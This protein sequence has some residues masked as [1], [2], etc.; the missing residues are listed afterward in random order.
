MQILEFTG[1]SL[2]FLD[3]LPGTAS[4]SSFVWIY[5]DR[6]ELPKHQALLQEAAQRLG[7]SPLL[8]L[9]WKDLGNDQHP[10]HYDSTSVY[11]LVIFRRLATQAEVQ[12]DA[13]REQ[14]IVAY[15]NQGFTARPRR[16]AAMPAAFARINSRAV[17]FAI[18]DRLLISVHPAGCVIANTYVQRFLSDAKLSIE[19]ASARSRLPASPADLALRTINTMVDSYLDLR[20]DLAT[21]LEQLQ[22][23]LIKP[24]SRFADWS[25]LMEARRQLHLLE[26]LCEGQHDAMQE[27]LDSLREQPLQSFSSDTQVA[28]TRRDALVARARDVGE[29]I[30][31]VMH[32]ARRLEQ[33]AETVVQIHFSVQGNRT[34]DIMRTL[35]AVTAIFLPLNLVT[36]FFGMN[37]E[38][39]PWIHSTSAMWTIFGI[40]AALA[41]A[42][43]VVFLRK[44]YIARTDN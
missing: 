32:H 22:G 31:R 24:N 1:D 21:Y 36:G 6:A 2:R 37:F 33:S 28:Q 30:D 29:H 13:E 26:D 23:E 3:E 17:G 8:D 43:I 27:W 25:S 4:G 34:N 11:D 10:S 41:L 35:T 5:L 15:H 40:M 42:V 44:R 19:T 9:H 39:L 20:K 7:G 16:S 12:Q 18:F 14:A 38:H